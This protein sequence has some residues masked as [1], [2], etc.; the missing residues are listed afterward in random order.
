[1]NSR[2]EAGPYK[3]NNTER[4]RGKS[5]SATTL[6]AP[7]RDASEASSEQRT[8]ELHNVCRVETCPL[9]LRKTIRL[10]HGPYRRNNGK[11]CNRAACDS[12]PICDVSLHN[13]SCRLT[14]RISDPA[15]ATPKMR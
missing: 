5:K 13:A 14:L 9:H 11:D 1:M 12:K 15:P 4:N 3:R 8:C 7:K 10:Q 6:I 2:C